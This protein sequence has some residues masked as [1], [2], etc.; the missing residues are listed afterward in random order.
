MPKFILI[1]FLSAVF[2]F[3]PYVH[4]QSFLPACAI[5]K[6]PFVETDHPLYSQLNKFIQDKTIPVDFVPTS[7]TRKNYLKIIHDQV[8]A[9]VQYQDS[10]GKIIDP[11]K[12]TEMYFTTPCFAHSVSVLAS[13]GYPAASSILEAGM[14]AMD[15]TTDQMAQNKSA[16]G[17][18]DFYTWPMMMAF[19]NFSKTAAA[20]RIRKWR[21]NLDSM[22]PGIFYAVKSGT[23]NNWNVVNLT[24][25]YFRYLE[26]MTDTAYLQNSLTLQINKFNEH[27]MYLDPSY[28]F[29]YDNFARAYLTSMLFFDYKGSSLDKMQKNLWKGA[30]TALFTQ[31]PFGELPTGYRS[32]QHIWNEADL[33]LIFEMYA[34]EYKKAGLDYEAGVFKRGARLALKSIASWIRPDGSGYIVKNKYPITAQWG[35]ESYSVHTCYNM[36][37]TSKLAAA[38]DAADTTIIE[39]PAPADVGGF[40]VHLPADFKK[41]IANSGGTY[42]EYDLNG[43]PKKTYTATG[44]I[45]V[46]LKGG[47]PQLGPS[48]GAKQAGGFDWSVGP[49]WK[50]GNTWTRVGQLTQSPDSVHI[51][52]E[53]NKKVRFEIKYNFQPSG[54]KLTQSYTVEPSGVTVEDEFTGVVQDAMKV[55]FLMLTWNGKDST[56]VS[57]NGNQA[58]LELEGKGVRFTLLEPAN[59]TLLKEPG[60]FSNRNGA[61]EA[62]YAEFPNMKTR[63]EIS[64][65]PKYEVPVHIPADISQNRIQSD[66]SQNR[67]FR[68]TVLNSQFKSFS[69]KSS[70]SGIYNIALFNPA[71]KM[72]FSW[73]DFELKKG[74]NKLE[75]KSTSFNEGIYFLKIY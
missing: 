51:L 26:G 13:S 4:G 9:F 7:I 30:W 47:H 55:D 11:V 62:A 37:A 6:K 15:Y 75:V 57:L 53:T 50:M 41:V 42:I 35:Y 27:G 67:N 43:D 3:A 56:H 32:S 18:G 69:F 17:H 66:V 20:S 8:A 68:F 72:L 58:T 12:K 73:P 5:A 1:F 60:T 48:D 25:E 74:K 49:A 24:G 29:A 61:L 23:G 54:L 38:W 2:L 59:K 63:Y 28:P 33:T 65:W 40:V 14:K 70:F 39:K 19:K 44:L 31:S 21:T 36:L 45:R 16:G 22:V 10:A 71:G 64:A 46:H 52:E 34:N